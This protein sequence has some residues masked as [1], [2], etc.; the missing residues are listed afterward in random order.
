MQFLHKT[1][2]SSPRILFK[3]FSGWNCIINQT[4]WISII[5]ALIHLLQTQ[6]QFWSFQHQTSP[7]NFRIVFF[8]FAL[9]FTVSSL[10]TSHFESN[11]S[12]FIITT[13]TSTLSG[14]FNNFLFHIDK[15]TSIPVFANIKVFCFTQIIISFTSSAIFLSKKWS[16]E[17][18]L[19]CFSIVS[20]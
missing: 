7:H 15:Q 4:G 6:L 8:L 3:T 9:S 2:Q 16:E 17:Y 12:L 1:I 10:I 19:A 14:I 11:S 13:W 20:L 18:I 5:F